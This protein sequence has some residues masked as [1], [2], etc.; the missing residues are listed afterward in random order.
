MKL[1]A[2]QIENENLKR[3]LNDSDL[4]HAQGP[5]VKPAEQ[6]DQKKKLGTRPKA[7]Q[8]PEAERLCVSHWGKKKCPGQDC[9]RVHLPQC[10]DL[11]CQGFGTKTDRMESGC[12]L[13]HITRQGNGPRP[14]DG[15]ERS[16]NAHAPKKQP[17]QGRHQKQRQ[18]QGHRRQ[19]H[20]KQQQQQGRPLQQRPAMTL[21][22]SPPVQLHIAPPPPPQHQSWA[23][24]AARGVVPTPSPHPIPPQEAVAKLYAL[25]ASWGY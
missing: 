24:V 10:P 4:N 19:E 6:P 18:G 15:G 16:R 11:K 9:R 14:R 21:T 25:L 20:G 1:R 23:S 12:S 22:P 2:V 13:W 8:R 5:S 17:T 3:E 7:D